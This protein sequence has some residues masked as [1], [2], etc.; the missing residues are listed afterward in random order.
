MPTRFPTD[1]KH[2]RDRAGKAR[3]TAERKTDPEAKRMM[4][5]IAIGYDKLAK[6]AEE[7]QLAAAKIQTETT[8][9][10]GLHGFLSRLSVVYTSKE[11]RPSAHIFYVG[12]RGLQS[13]RGPGEIVETRR[14]PGVIVTSG[15]APPAQPAAD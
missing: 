4:L 1:A 2:W 7:R 13:P 5:A 15:L 9:P 8:T 6:R 14:P 11:V 10:H 3:A 12:S